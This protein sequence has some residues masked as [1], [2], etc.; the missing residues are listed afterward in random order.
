MSNLFGIGLSGLGAAQAGLNATSNNI[1]NVNTPGYTRRKTQ[2]AEVAGS[3]HGGGVTVTG[4]Q[5]QYAQFLTTQLNSA[6]ST[7][8]A[9]SSHLDQISQIDNLL[10][11]STAGLAPR[12]QGF[13]DSLSTLAGSPQDS[14]AR[15][16][17]LGSAKDM[18]SQFRSFA[19]TLSNMGDAVKKQVS[20]A[21]KEVNNNASQIAALN[22]Q[23]T[24]TQ[25]R[26]GQPPNKLLDQ[27][28]ELVAKTSKLI[29]VAVT[30]NDNGS[31]NLTV[32]GQ[33]LVDATG[34]H[35]LTT[36]ASAA[37]PTQQRLGSVSADGSTREIPNQ[38]V[39]GGEIGG[40]LSFASDS[41]APAQDKL[42]QTAHDLAA[43]VNAQH[44]KGTD[45]N[46]NAGKALFTTSPSQPKVYADANNTGNA[47]VSSAT[48]AA[49]QTD[50][51]T[52]DNY[53]VA[54]VGGAYQV[55]R[56]SD[57]SALSAS[58]NSGSN[59]LSF[60]GLDVAVSGTPNNGD[61][62]TV[63]PLDNAAS[64]LSVAIS[65]PAKLAA[66]GASGSGA[67]AGGPGDNTN[68]NALA[69]LQQA[70]T[71]EGNR[72]FSDNYSQLVGD[73]GN[74]AQSLQV[75]SDSESALTN[76]LSQAQQSVSGV[77]LDEESVNLMYYQ[78]MYQANARVIKTASTVFNTVLG[79]GN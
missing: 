19:S 45:L 51:V 13:F 68:A 55:T 41:L 65:D 77:N 30:K 61:A 42:N 15:N 2:L 63:R 49:D 20:S 3:N 11:D 10:S 18:A 48:F 25:A 23:I 24:V 14:S 57:G 50:A 34:S 60:G 6:Q 64:A 79:L 5:R 4:V 38:R 43:A 58:F 62:F 54:Y 46:G 44:K 73:I 1:S 72:S 26:T 76:E 69:A 66:A 28:D 22:K 17:V 47:T 70:K 59:T 12:I 33:S 16:A 8:S 52:A 9:T 21:V 29:N 75:N 36:V 35:K 56:A 7:A 67:G 40:L 32:G 37:D 53:H 31:Y 71:V 39:P 27:R 78:Q 74:K